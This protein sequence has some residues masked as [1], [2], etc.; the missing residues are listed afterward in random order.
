MS[1]EFRHALADKN[2]AAIGLHRCVQSDLR[3]QFAIAQTGGQHHARRAKALATR[4]DLV[5]VG[6]AGDAAGAVSATEPDPALLAGRV[7]RAQQLERIH[8]TVHRRVAGAHHVGAYSRQLC[9]QG[10]RVQHLVGILAAQVVA[11]VDQL[12]FTSAQVDK[13]GWIVNNQI[14][15]SAQL[16]EG[17]IVTGGLEQYEDNVYIVKIDE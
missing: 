14:P 6:S 7:E 2:L 4:L 10:C 5:T 1:K 17:G 15:F 9:L 16:T 12:G 8:M 3:R 13:T 11:L